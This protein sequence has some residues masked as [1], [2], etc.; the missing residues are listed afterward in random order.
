MQVKKVIEQA[1]HRNGIGGA[2]AIISLFT[3]EGDR[4]KYLGI[5]TF[6]D[7]PENPVTVRG[8]QTQKGAYR[9]HWIRDFATHTVVLRLEETAALNI[10]AHGGNSWYGSDRCGEALAKAYIEQCMAEEPRPW[11]P[12]LERY[13]AEVPGAFA[14]DEHDAG[15]HVLEADLDCK[16]CLDI[17]DERNKMQ[18]ASV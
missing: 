8:G 3:V 15:R 1:W 16:D 18:E 6:P 13:H 2:P 4:G 11:D 12:A 9:L 17:I 7:R 10:A 5:T 14:A